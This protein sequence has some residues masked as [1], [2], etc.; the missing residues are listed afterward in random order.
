M[1]PV[2]TF[3]LMVASA[4]LMFLYSVIDNT[5]RLYANLVMSVLS[6]ITFIFLGSAASIGAVAYTSAAI[7]AIMSLFGIMAFG[8]ALFMAVDVIFEA[9]NSDSEDSKPEDE[10]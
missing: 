1:I 7:G 4:L 8:Y 3:N 9:I 10:I 5:N 6:G 2:S